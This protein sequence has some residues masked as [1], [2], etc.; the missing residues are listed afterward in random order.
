MAPLME[1]RAI[2]WNLFHGRDFAPDPALH[3]WRSRL[4][5]TTERNATHVQVNHDLAREFAAILCASR[6][7]VALL[8]ECPPRWCASLAAACRAAAQQSLTSRNWLGSVRGTLAR[9]NPDLLGAWEGGSNLTLV[10]GPEG[11]SGLLDQRDLV[12]SHRPERRMMAFARLRSGVCVANLHASTIPELAEAELRHAARTAIGWAGD[13]PLILGGDFNLQPSRSRLFAELAERF[14]LSAP[15]GPDSIDHLLA[16]RLA[17]VD[18]PTPWAPRDREL[19]YDGL[20]LRLSDHAPV[21]ARFRIIDPRD[22]E[23][24][25]PPG[26]R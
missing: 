20:R 15:T 7:D 8:Q 11:E 4:L 6:W 2:T 23:P 24:T 21:E 19:R 26:M 18:P 16:R 1:L 12:L 5:R 10:R 14:D 25:E 9:W 17:I 3:T 13:S 22:R